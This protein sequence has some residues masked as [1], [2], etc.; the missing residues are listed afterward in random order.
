MSLYSIF[1]DRLFR[2]SVSLVYN[3]YYSM[4]ISKTVHN[5]VMPN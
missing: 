2:L 1:L 3:V 4:Y 5:C